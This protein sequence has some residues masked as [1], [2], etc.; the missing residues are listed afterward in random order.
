[1][2]GRQKIKKTDYR[3]SVSDHWEVTDRVFGH[4][5]HAA[6]ISKKDDLSVIE[7]E[8]YLLSASDEIMSDDLS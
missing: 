6:S 8:K 5:G 7:L 2:S 3:R 1:L 4:G